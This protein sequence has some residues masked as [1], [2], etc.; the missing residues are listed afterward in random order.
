MKILYFHN[1]SSTFVEK[2]IEIL[3]SEH[4][5][6]VFH[7]NVTN[8]K[9]LIFE[10]FKQLIELL[11]GNTKYDYYFIQFAGF[12]SVLPIIFSKIF[13]VKTIIVLGGTDC[14]SF[15]SINYGNF[16]RYFLGKATKFSLK[17]ANLLLPVDSSL[18]KY[19]YNY[20]NNDFPFQGYLFHAPKVKTK[21]QV[22]YNGY[23]PE[24]WS[25][26]ENKE[27][28][29]F[30]TIGANLG[31]RF[32][33][34]LKGIDLIVSLAENLPD[35]KFYIVGGQNIKIPTPSNVVL[36]PTIPN[37]ELGTFLSS[38]KYYLQLS[39][40]EGFPNALCEAML[41]GCI[42]IVSNVGAMPFIVNDER[43]ILVKKDLKLLIKLVNQI[44]LDEINPLEIRNKITSNF[45]FDKRKIQILHALE[46]NF[47]S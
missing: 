2:D 1:G 3:K 10:F 35:Y 12:H 32:G 22:I 18:V 24:K 28:K 47:N 15:P 17:H 23:A 46:K 38:K 45:H 33:L 42:P 44:K 8:K 21:Y 36:S 30:V 13:N 20:Q 41:C 27:E 26:S 14:V 43:L 5:L 40:S 31:S 25:I 7:F 37:S 16:N 29:S 9:K 34:Q 4:D 19:E 39:M 6:K 11:K